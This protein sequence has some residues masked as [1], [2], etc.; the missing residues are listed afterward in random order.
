MGKK[1]KIKPL[2][3]LEIEF[4]DGTKKECILNM[5]ALLVFQDEFGDIQKIIKDEITKPILLTAKLL[6]AGLKVFDTSVSLEEAQAIALG[7]GIE[8]QL[9]MFSMLQECFGDVEELLSD[10]TSNIKKKTKSMMQKM[11]KQKT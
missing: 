5:Q 4:A 6:Y 8:L 9:E 2:E 11:K 1:I 10:S 3:S 7:G